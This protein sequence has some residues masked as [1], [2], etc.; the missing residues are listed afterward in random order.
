MKGL[1]GFLKIEG[2]T[3]FLILEGLNGFLILEGLNSF[4]SLEGLNGFLARRS[5]PGRAVCLGPGRRTGPGRVV[6][7]WVVRGAGC[8]V[9]SRVNELVAQYQSGPA[10]IDSHCVHIMTWTA[11]TGFSPWLWPEKFFKIIFK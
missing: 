9:V 2:L 6:Q 1:N 3:G 7:S 4:L 10:C 8:L 5:G 11:G